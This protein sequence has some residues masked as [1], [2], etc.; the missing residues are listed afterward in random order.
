[1]RMASTN[2]SLG[3]YHLAQGQTKGT[4]VLFHP[5]FPF[6][7]H[8]KDFPCLSN[9]QTLLPPLPWDSKGAIRHLCSPYWLCL[10]RTLLC[11]HRP[12][13]DNPPRY[14]QS[15]PF[16]F[17]Q[18]TCPILVH[19]AGTRKETEN[20]GLSYMGH[21]LWMGFILFTIGFNVDRLCHS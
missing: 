12:A 10:N 3:I 8:I 5:T 16:F 6:P 4:R 17:A 20:G 1:M 14:P 13:G 7:V 15:T 11:E 19:D 2:I 9:S 21:Q 18:H